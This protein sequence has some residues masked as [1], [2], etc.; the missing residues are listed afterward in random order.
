[1]VVFFY[2]PNLIQKT[3][4]NF[5]KE[6]N[7]DISPETASEYLDGLSGLFLAF[8]GKQTPACPA[9]DAGVAEVE[10]NLINDLITN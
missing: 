3:I 1:M 8:A 7:L 6:N 2:S 5:K 10:N 9:R 4:E